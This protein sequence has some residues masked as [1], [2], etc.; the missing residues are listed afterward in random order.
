[1][2]F[3]GGFCGGGCGAHIRQELSWQS[4]VFI[5]VGLTKAAFRLHEDLG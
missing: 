5:K 2:R 1:M 4:Q 3:Q